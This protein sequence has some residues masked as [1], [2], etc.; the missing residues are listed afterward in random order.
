MKKSFLINDR[1]YYNTVMTIDTISE[2]DNLSG[3]KNIKPGKPDYIVVSE[4]LENIRNTKIS[5][6]TSFDELFE[7]L[8]KIGIIETN[9]GGLVPPSSFIRIINQ[10]R[11][12]EIPIEKITRDAGLRDKVVELLKG[13]K[14][15]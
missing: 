3:E 5:K 10:I 7:V 1:K 13:E 4:N 11:N 15:H 12:R 2:H 8:N 6:V 9:K 14:I